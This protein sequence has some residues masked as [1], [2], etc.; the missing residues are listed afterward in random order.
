V[1][2]AEQASTLA[3]QVAKEESEERLKAHN[4][5]IEMMK[6]RAEKFEL[7]MSRLTA[8]F[9]TK[10]VYDKLE[11]KITGGENVGKGVRL[12]FSTLAAILASVAVIIGIVAYAADK[13]A[14]G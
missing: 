4:G 13:F 6:D 7:A 3:L 1:D 2:K 5:L 10:E 14:G 8:T 9:V 11:K 12:T